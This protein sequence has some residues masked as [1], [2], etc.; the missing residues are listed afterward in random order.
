MTFNKHNISNDG[1]ETMHV[2][3]KIQNL[4]LLCL[5]CTN[6]QLPIYIYIYIYIENFRKTLQYNNTFHEQLIIQ[7]N[8]N[9][10]P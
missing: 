4:S 9:G 5:M 10:T 1:F 6:S 7:D 2:I 3:K 8:E